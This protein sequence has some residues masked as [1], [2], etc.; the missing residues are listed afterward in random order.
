MKTG[1]VSPYI[2]IYIYIYIYQL[3][4]GITQNYA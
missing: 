2:Y 4:Q 1:D 3:S